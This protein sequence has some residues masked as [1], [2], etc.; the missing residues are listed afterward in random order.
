MSTLELKGQK[1]K[2]VKTIQT[3]VDNLPSFFDNENIKI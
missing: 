1:W 2:M 3:R